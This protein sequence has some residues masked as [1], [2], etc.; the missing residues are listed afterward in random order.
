MN[1][2]LIRNLT[3]ATTLLSGAAM[4]APLTVT[5][6]NPGEKAIFPV[7]SSLVA[8][9][10]EAILIDAQFDVKNGQALVDMIK[11]SGKQLTTVYISA[12]DPDFYFGLEPIMKA[13]PKV[14]VLADQH[15]V[16]HINKTK[17]DK[18]TYWGPI[19][20]AGAPKALT[21]PEV[22]TASYLTLEGE[23]IEIKEMNTPTAYLWAPSIK[24]ALGG[25]PVYSGVHVWMADSQTKEARAHW[26]KTLNELLA[27]K[28]ERVVPGHFLG[29][30]PKGTEAVT[31]TRD[32][33]QRFEQEL[34][35]SKNSGELIEGLKKAFPS[36][37]VDD[38]LAIGAKVN[39]GEMK[40]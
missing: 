26:V 40:W 36:L 9:D 38:G 21:V 33:V 29:T 12:G 27:M 31:F 5:V 17:D 11:Q 15:V 24:T 37:P 10:K 39:T 20:G 13:F 30:A 14:K 22:M 6:Y 34:A 4:A 2:T 32:Y 3:L 28:P 35:K 8:G 19:L 25:V 18:L 7:S 23:K 16:D 1:N